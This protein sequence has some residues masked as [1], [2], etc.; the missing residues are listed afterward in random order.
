ML[1]RIVWRLFGRMVR[2]SFWPLSQP[3][4]FMKKSP[5]PGT[6]EVIDCA[7]NRTSPMTMSCVSCL[8]ASAAG[9]V[10]ATARVNGPG[11]SPAL[12]LRRCGVLDVALSVGLAGRGEQGLDLERLLLQVER[13]DGLRPRQHHVVVVRAQRRDDVVVFQGG[14]DVGGILRRDLVRV[15]FHDD[16]APHLDPIASSGRGEVGQLVVVLEH[17]EEELRASPVGEVRAQLVGIVRGEVVLR[18][19]DQHDVRVIRA[20]PWP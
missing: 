17:V 3:R 13:L 18:R 9:S 8:L 10:I 14:D 6:A 4:L 2:L 15:A 16:D 5:L 12:P 20:P 11:M 1:S 7:R 19:Q